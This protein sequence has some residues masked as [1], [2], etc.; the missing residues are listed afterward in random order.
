MEKSTGINHLHGSELLAETVLGDTESPPDDAQGELNRGDTLGRYVVLDRLGS[1]AMGVVYAAFDPELN[2]KVALKLVLP[3]HRDAGGTPRLLREAQALAKLAHPNVVAVHDVGTVDDKVWLA[4]EF[5]EGQTLRDWLKARWKPG[6]RPWREI[7]E[8]MSKAGEGLAAAH[9]A[10]LLHR[11]FKP[12]NVMVAVDGRV[13]VMDLGLARAVGATTE[14]SEE[15]TNPALDVELTDIGVVLGTPGYMAPEQFFGACVGTAADQFAYSIT[16]W[17]ALC[18]E[19]PFP[20]DSLIDLV[21]NVRTNNIR[22]MGPGIPRWLRNICLKGLSTAPKSRFSSMRELLHALERGQRRTWFMRAVAIVG[23]VFLIAAGLLAYHKF[24][25]REQTRDC[26]QLGLEIQ[27]VWNGAIQ[28]EIHSSLMATGHS[29]AETTSQKIAPSLAA[30]TRAWA[31]ARTEVCLHRTVH[32]TWEEELGERAAWCL[33]TRQME[34][35]ALVAELKHADTTILRNAANAVAKLA[36]PSLCREREH[37]WRMD[38]PPA[39]P[40]EQREV[41]RLLSRAGA[42]EAGGNYKQGL[43]VAREALGA[44]E[45]LGWSPLVAQARGKVGSLL[46]VN[47][48][49]AEAETMLTKAFFGTSRSVAFEAARHLS[50]TVGYAVGRHREGLLWARHAEAKLT[51]IGETHGLRAALVMSTGYRAWGDGVLR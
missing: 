10:N 19:R 7:V 14:P 16:L 48:E 47:G 4:M 37:L 35:E 36:D 25:I 26:E 31:Q 13:R 12:D 32:Q 11:D 21:E 9:E 6:K 50:Y 49:Y 3:R 41:R 18:G 38:P 30:H 43:T 24:R 1:G 34:L 28:S 42:L 39:D 2:R 5:V 44:A 40:A 23:V 22:T 15:V 29:F 20:G 46:M 45:Q 27:S 8:V 17:E 33:E 51:E